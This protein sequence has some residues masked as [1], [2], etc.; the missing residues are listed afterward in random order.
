[1]GWKM[2]GATLLATLAVSGKALSHAVIIASTPAPLSHTQ[3]GHLTLNLRYNSRI[4]AARSKLQLG[5]GGKL[6]RLAVTPGTSPDTLQAEADLQPGAWEI[7]WQVLAV[8][9]HVTRG[10]IPF[11]VDEAAGASH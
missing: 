6:Q 4:D 2:I 5:H 8:D 3:P 1:M 10:R 9:G 11:T 7:R